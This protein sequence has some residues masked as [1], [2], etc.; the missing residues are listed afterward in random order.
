MRIFGSFEINFN[1]LF[2]LFKLV[3]V[4]LIKNKNNYLKK[5]VYIT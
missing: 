5:I 4:S 2:G 1:D 3:T